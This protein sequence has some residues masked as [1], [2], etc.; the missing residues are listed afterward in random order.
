[1]NQGLVHLYTGDG[2]GKTTCSLGL[3]LRALGAGYHVHY[4]QF[5]KMGDSSEFKV[6]EELEGVETAFFG[7]GKFIN[8]EKKDE[9]YQAEAKSNRKGI[10]KVKALFGEIEGED[11]EIQHLVVLDE[12]CL[13]LFFDILSLEEVLNIIDSKPESVELVI[14]GRR[15]PRKLVLACDYVSE[16]KEVKHPFRY[17]IAARKGIES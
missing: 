10:A 15:A 7:L 8:K 13:L 12:L 5:M 11:D 4:F 6:L 1:M 2:K 14:T 3:S 9:A 17:G 16:I